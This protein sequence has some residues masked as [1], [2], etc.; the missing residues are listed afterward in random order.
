MSSPQPFLP[1]LQI[2]HHLSSCISPSHVTQLFLITSVPCTY[3]PTEVCCNHKFFLWEHSPPLI[4]SKKWYGSIKSQT[5]TKK[6]LSAPTLQEN[7]RKCRAKSQET[8]HYLRRPKIFC[9]FCFLATPKR[10]IKYFSYVHLK[11]MLLITPVISNMLLN[12]KYFPW[13][14]SIVII[15]LTSDWLH[16]SRTGGWCAVCTRKQTHYMC[17]LFRWFYF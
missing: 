9:L 11:I 12:V 10:I 5:E 1:F 8:I 2:P 13:V 3:M 16:M 14:L 15:L 6:S 7:Q 17:K 4:L